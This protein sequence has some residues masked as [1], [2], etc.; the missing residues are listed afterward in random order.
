M[1]PADAMARALALA[2]RGRGR[3]SP[4]PLVG[5]V[6]VR[7]GVVLSEGFHRGAGNPHAEVEALRTLGGKA[8]GATIYVTLEPC[9]HHGR[10]P[11]CT[12]ALLASGVARV[13]VAM[14]DPDPRVSGQGIEAL[15]AAGLSVEVGL[16]EAEARA[17]NEAWLMARQRQRPFVV[18]KAGATLDGRI[19][20]TTGESRW[21]T[22][23]AA[24]QRV[25]ELRDQL[26]A[27][28]VGAGT[29]RADDPQLTTRL[30][31]GRHATAV[32]LDTQLSIS[33]DAAVLSAGCPVILAC[34]EDA[35]ARD[36]PAT[37]LRLPRGA[38]GLD[39]HALMRA[40]VDR[41]LYS[42]LV[43]GGGQVHRAFVEAGLVDR[44]LL[45]LAPKALA[46]GPGWL[47]GPGYSLAAAPQWRLTAVEALQGDALLTLEP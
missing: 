28:L 17:C 8:E 3:T 30:P 1:S 27:V 37:I 2:A 12:E 42:L 13:V 26:D 10:T 24:R 34:A 18:L 46:A 15:R 41:N 19:A 32:I 7:D 20:S 36:L 21:I 14:V 35:P 40:L 45:F 44:L 47:G 16:M 23:P 38:H 22:G 33:A 43:E 39:L 9:C 31:G 29:L 5:A 25:H 4:N 11:P 6:I